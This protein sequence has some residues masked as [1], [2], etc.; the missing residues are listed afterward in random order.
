[1]GCGAQPGPERR[2]VDDVAGDAAPDPWRRVLLRQDPDAR[3]DLSSAIGA[4]QLRP[5]FHAK[6]PGKL[7]RRDQLGDAK[8]N[9][10][11][12]EPARQSMRRAVSAVSP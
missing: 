10:E 7:A 6:E 4:D 2:E 9:A 11:P 5:L 8:A 12:A 1:M 3:H